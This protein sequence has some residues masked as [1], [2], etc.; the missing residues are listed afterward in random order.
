[1][2]VISYILIIGGVFLI[3]GATIKALL[4]GSIIDSRHFIGISDT[5]GLNLLVIYAIINNYLTILEGL[6]IIL[7]LI[8]SGTVLS[9]IISRSIVKNNR[10]VK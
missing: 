10:K 7:I 3:V 5:V 9:H 8:V 2:I 4:S 6:T 1:M